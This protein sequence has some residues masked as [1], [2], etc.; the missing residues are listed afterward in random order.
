MFSGTAEGLTE[1]GA[2]FVDTG[3]GSDDVI[4]MMRI[5]DSIGSTTADWVAFELDDASVPP[6]FLIEFSTDPAYEVGAVIT[7]H[8]GAS[9]PTSAMAPAL[10]VIIDNGD[11]GYST[12][13]TWAK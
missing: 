12:V 7:D 2:T 6:D 4:H 8:L 3:F 9:N 1:T 10:H 11:V 5:G 13:R